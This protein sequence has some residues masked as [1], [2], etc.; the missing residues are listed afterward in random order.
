[1]SNSKYFALGLCFL[2]VWGVTQQAG[3]YR[4][5]LQNGLDALQAIPDWL[6]EALEAVIVL[7]SNQYVRSRRTSVVT[8]SQDLAG[9]HKAWSIRQTICTA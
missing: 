2:A 4:Q 1:M 6:L 8:L 9:W 7:R 5:S 3:D